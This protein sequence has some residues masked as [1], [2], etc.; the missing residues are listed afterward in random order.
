MF[1]RCAIIPLALLILAGAIPGLN[2]WARL[3]QARDEAAP[4]SDPAQAP[5]G[6]AR[7]EAAT[8]NAQAQSADEKAIRAVDETFVAA[9]NQGDSK[10]LASRF[11]EDAEVDRGRRRTVPGAGR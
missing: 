4:R 7:P 2:G 8:A 3:G 6:A 10:A 9:Y 5:S 1:S 11:T